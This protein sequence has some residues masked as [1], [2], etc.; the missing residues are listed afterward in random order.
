MVEETLG[1]NVRLRQS[2]MDNT[3]DQVLVLYQ[4]VEGAAVVDEDYGSAS[5][6]Y[7]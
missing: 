3:G 1:T 2:S 6:F 5:Q 4:V 7:T